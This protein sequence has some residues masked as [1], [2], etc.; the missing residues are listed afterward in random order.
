M[1]NG[2][3]VELIEPDGSAD[4]APAIRRV[5]PNRVIAVGGDGLI[6][7]ALPALVEGEIALGIVPSGTGN[8]FAR[9]LALPKRRSAAV[10][11]AVGP[12]TAV[13]L[14]RVEHGDGLETYAATAV[15][16]GFSGRVNATA[17][18]RDFP[19]GQ[20]KYTVASFTE[21]RRLESFALTVAQLEGGNNEGGDR[22]DPSGACAFFA[23]ANTRFFGGGMA[24]APRA[25]AADGLLHLIVVGGVPAWKLALV[26]PSVFIGQHVR[27]PRVTEVAATRADLDHDQEVWADGERIGSGNISVSVVPMALFVAAF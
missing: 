11:R 15:T 10:G 4:I 2:Q 22:P 12:A 8:D 17:N 18:A 1:T 14:L 27:H 24:I 5:A 7:H 16:A 26:L 25:E 13:D 21:L 19:K 20:L 6:H 9:A 3:K 23:V